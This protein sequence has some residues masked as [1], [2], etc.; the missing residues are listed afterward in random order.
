MHHFHPQD[1][2]VLPFV[3]LRDQQQR[4]AGEARADAVVILVLGLEQ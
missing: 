3:A 2:P 4:E 1:N